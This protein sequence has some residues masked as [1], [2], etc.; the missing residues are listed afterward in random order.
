MVRMRNQWVPIDPRVWNSDMD[1]TINIALGQ[2][3]TDEKMQLMALVAQKQEQILQT[4]GPNNPLVTLPQYSNT[5]TKM[6]E[7][8]GHK[9][10]SGFFNKLPKDFQLPP[11]PPPVDP[12]A[13]AAQLLAQVERE[14]AQAKLQVDS[15]KLQFEQQASA[16]KLQAET[17]IQAAKLQLDRDK[18]EAEFARKQLELEMQ[19]AK[20]Q[21]EL[22]LKE[23]ESVLKQLSALRGNQQ[24][25]EEKANA[26]AEQEAGET[27]QEGMLAQAIQAIGGLIAQ[28]QAQ[29]AQALT[30]PKMVIRDQTGKVV[31]VKPMEQ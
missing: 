17:Q 10:T 11:A 30:A 19:A 16:A 7:L 6:L 25:D 29:T 1:V 15:A 24:N 18:M 13:Q 26:Y 23:A 28:T 31:G 12:N 9:D 20:I 22:Q 4:M 21:A 27:R 14:K 3:T 2:G 8:A 5:L